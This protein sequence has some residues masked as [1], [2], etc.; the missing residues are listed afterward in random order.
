M[1]YIKTYEDLNTQEYVKNYHLRQ[2][3]RYNEYPKDKTKVVL[4]DYNDG[5]LLMSKDKKK[6]FV[7]RYRDDH[8]KY[9][10]SR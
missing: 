8:G 1:K 4:E 5:D 2:F 9:G 7:F 10:C 6:F 3:N